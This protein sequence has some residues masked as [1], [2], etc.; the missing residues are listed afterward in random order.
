MVNLNESIFFLS[1][2]NNS[3][4]Q[5]MRWMFD[6]R[7]WQRSRRALHGN[8]LIFSLVGIDTYLKEIMWV[9]GTV[10]ARCNYGKPRKP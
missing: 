3:V 1:A 4:V 10:N 9:D 7:K 2:R 8:F 6:D 5:Y